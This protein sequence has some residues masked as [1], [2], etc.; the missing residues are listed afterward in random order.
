M[1]MNKVDGTPFVQ[2]HQLDKYTRADAHST[3]ASRNPVVTPDTAA[4]ERTL[5][6]AIISDK[7]LRFMELHNIM[8][9]GREALE[10]TPELRAERL[11]QVRA[12]LAS[13][14]YNSRDVYRAVAER[15]GAVIDEVEAV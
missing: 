11:E 6:Q 12:R 5:D 3:A 2:P 9:A 15:L 8:Q 14:Y 10:A 4:T 1:A 13:G 7:A